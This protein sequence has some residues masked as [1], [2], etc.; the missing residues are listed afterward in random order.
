M[1]ARTFKE[2]TVT[3]ALEA[4]GAKSA[5]MDTLSHLVFEEDGTAFRRIL[6]QVSEDYIDVPLTGSALDYERQLIEAKL[7]MHEAGALAR[8]HSELGQLG[9]AKSSTSS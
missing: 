2:V 4:N 6:S 9:Q 5:R 8:K 7:H 3:V 1:I